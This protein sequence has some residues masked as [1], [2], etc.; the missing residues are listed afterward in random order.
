M[1]C[2]C[3]ACQRAITYPEQAA[4]CMEACPHCSA[5]MI[6]PELSGP[7]VARLLR[8]PPKPPVFGIRIHPLAAVIILVLLVAV[9]LLIAF[10]S[11]PNF[12]PT[13]NP[14]QNSS[15]GGQPDFNPLK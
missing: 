3:P 2:N 4:G 9:G 5:R 8:R 6:L 13:F 7:Q 11:N 12:L 14:F 15:P 1:N 10:A